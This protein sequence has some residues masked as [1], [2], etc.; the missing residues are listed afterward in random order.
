MTATTFIEGIGTFHVPAEP[1][2]R[3]VDSAACVRGICG[4]YMPE[5]ARELNEYGDRCGQEYSY[6]HRRDPE[7]VRRALDIGCNVLSWTVWIS[8]IWW[9]G[10]LERVDAY[11][12]QASVIACARRNVALVP[13]G[14]EVNIHQAA[15]TTDPAPMFHEDV[16]TGCSRTHGVAAGEP[17]NECLRIGTTGRGTEAYAVAAVHPRDL[18][19]AEGIKC[20]AEGPEADIFEHYP[21]WAGVL[22]VAW[23]WHSDDARLRTVAACKRAGLVLLQNNCG[24]G[25]Q[26]VQVWGR[27]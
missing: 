13:R 7:P 27:R 10:T 8:R 15:V 6:L 22:V 4:T 24:E 2:A 23:E 19:P 14:I 20:D 9:A 12:P 5:V 16:R 3:R 25:P 1:E 21:H 17:C 11:D 26:G 18:P